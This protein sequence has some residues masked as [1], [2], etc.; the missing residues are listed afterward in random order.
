MTSTKST[1]RRSLA[2]TVLT[3]G[4]LGTV[5]QLDLSGYGE[6][7]AIELSPENDIHTYSVG[8]DGAVAVSEDLNAVVMA[9]ITLLQT[10]SAYRDL[11][12]MAQAQKRTG[13]IQCPLFFSAPDTGDSIFERNAIFTTF[14][15]LGEEAEAQDRSISIMLPHGRDQMTFGVAIPG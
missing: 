8:Q 1:V 3:V 11:A 2:N 14:P 12:A 4:P 7:G 13:I 6:G 15:D 9:E 10:T 5:P